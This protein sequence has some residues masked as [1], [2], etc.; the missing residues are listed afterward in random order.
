MTVLPKGVRYWSS[1]RSLFV[2]YVKVHLGGKVKM[3][4]HLDGVVKVKVHLGGMV[5]GWGVVVTA[6][7]LHW[8][9]FFFYTP[10]YHLSFIIIKY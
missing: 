3:G 4:V 7:S 2:S 9:I 6:A 1:L 10:F 5:I 8:K